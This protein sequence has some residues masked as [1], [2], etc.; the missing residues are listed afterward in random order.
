[1]LLL[2]KRIRSTNL[3]HLW[4]DFLFTNFINN[5]ISEASGNYQAVLTSRRD[6]IVL[7]PIWTWGQNHV[8]HLKQLQ[9]LI[10]TKTIVITEN[11]TNFLQP[12]SELV[13]AMFIGN[14]MYLHLIHLQFFLIKNVLRN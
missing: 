5:D 10:I 9:K 2:N 4:W 12:F 7:K 8:T 6:C 14:K 11:Y 13:I 1:M 3:L